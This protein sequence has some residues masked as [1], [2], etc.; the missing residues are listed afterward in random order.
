MGTTINRETLRRLA[1]E[2]GEETVTVLLNVFSDELNRYQSQL[3]HEPSVSD[4]RDI[5]HAIKSSAASF[6]ADDLAEFAQECESRVKLGQDVWV[7]DH[8]PELTSM[9]KG[10]A[11]EYRALAIDE[12]LLDSL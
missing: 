4:V 10:A 1:A 3:S 9:L 11:T 8:L 12:H 5:S 7:R 6:G 2:V